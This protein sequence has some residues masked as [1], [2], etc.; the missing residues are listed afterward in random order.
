MWKRDNRES[1]RLEAGLEG[2]EVEEVEADG[3]WKGG[4]RWAAEREDVVYTPISDSNFVRGRGDLPRS[5]GLELGEIYPKG[6]VL[7]ILSVNLG[8]FRHY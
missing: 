5:F 4:A 2:R 1:A 6:N 3:G 7:G 8:P